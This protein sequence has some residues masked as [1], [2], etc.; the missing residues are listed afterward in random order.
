MKR[1]GIG[2]SVLL[3]LVILSCT[4]LLLMPSR[5]RRALPWSATDIRENYSSAR[6]GA[7]YSR[8]LRARIS[9]SDFPAYAARLNLDRVYSYADHAELPLSWS[10]CDEPW[11][12]PPASLEGARFE[13]DPDHNCHAIAKYENGY[14]DFDA[15][16]W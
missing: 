14:V 15:F 11:W 7:D 3:V 2:C 4:G 5:A 6:F 8:C 1:I 9:E 10:W 13:Y 12:N 16:A